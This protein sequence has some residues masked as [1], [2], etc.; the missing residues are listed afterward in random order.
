MAQLQMRDVQYYPNE[1]MGWNSWEMMDKIKQFR[2][3]LKEQPAPKDGAKPTDNDM[4][5]AFADWGAA[6]TP[7][8]VEAMT[9]GE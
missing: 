3:W 7:P 2:R 8:A 5:D 1:F 4:A 9:Q 6:W